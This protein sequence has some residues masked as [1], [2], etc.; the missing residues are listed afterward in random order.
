M[1]P[2]FTSVVYKCLILI[3][4]WNEFRIWRTEDYTILRDIFLKK[5]Y[6]IGYK[7]KFLLKKIKIINYK[8]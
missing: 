4:N 7:N 2:K 6:Q 8:F 5:E 1:K 3:L